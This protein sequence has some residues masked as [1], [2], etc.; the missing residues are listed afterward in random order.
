MTDE[1]KAELLAEMAK[2]AKGDFEGD[3]E[4]GHGWADT[5]LCE[6]LTELGFPELVKVF[7]EVEKW[8]A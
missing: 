7:D 6:A 3:A 4:T 1:R 5:L 2:L 8:Y